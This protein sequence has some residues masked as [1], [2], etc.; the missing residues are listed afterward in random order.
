MSGEKILG[1]L[2][3]RPLLAHSHPTFAEML[4]CVQHDNTATGVT[5]SAVKVSGKTACAESLGK[6]AKVTEF[7]LDSQM[8]QLGHVIVQDQVFF[9]FGQVLGMLCQQLL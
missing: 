3:N 1:R 4:H 9:L 2:I 7:S 5:L 6:K 8:I